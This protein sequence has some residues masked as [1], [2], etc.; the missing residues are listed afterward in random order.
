MA[1]KLERKLVKLSTQNMITGFL[2]ILPAFTLYF[3][4]VIYPAI[5]AAWVGFHR[6][7]GFSAMK[8]IGI[9]NYKF[10]LNDEVYWLALLHSLQYAL[11]VT[12]AKN[13][14]ALGLAIILNRNIFAKSFFR[15]TIFMPVTLAFVVVGVLWS[16]IYN[17]T[18]GL[19]NSLLS[20]LGWEE[21]IQGWLSNPKIALYSIM[22]VDIWR[23]TG[24]HMVILLAGLQGIPKELYESAEI[25]G[26]N[27]W[28]QLTHITVPMLKPILFVSVIL[29][30]TGGFV[31][32]YDFVY[33][34]TGG[35]P[36]HATE[37]ALTWIV[38]TAFTYNSVGKANA[39]SVILFVILAV[40]SLPNF[41][42]NFRESRQI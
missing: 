4:F 14:L 3:L 28:K 27:D 15:T 2:M 42:K 41:I 35:G 25:D 32:N 34:M 6:W 36:N 5:Q 29:S 18:F 31:S 9:N 13:I 10:I 17:P 22:V 39:M 26:A 11:I 37:V 21:L 20:V 8:W 33:T 7:D 30:F 24:F 16:W 38:S 19:L 12:L 23:W 1:K 40:F